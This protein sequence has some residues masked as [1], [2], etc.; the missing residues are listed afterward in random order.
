MRSGNS[1]MRR[2]PRV[3]LLDA[4][5]TAQAIQRFAAARTEEAYGN[6]HPT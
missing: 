3:H 5:D 1:P 2:D 6:Q 4:L